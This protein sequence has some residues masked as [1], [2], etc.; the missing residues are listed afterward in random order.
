M[1]RVN[2]VTKLMQQQL[3]ITVKLHPFHRG[4]FPLFHLKFYDYHFRNPKLRKRDN[5]EFLLIQ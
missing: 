3:E 2:K 4:L 5:K 1:S